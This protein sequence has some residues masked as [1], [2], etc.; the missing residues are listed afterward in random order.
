MNNNSLKIS[1]IIPVYNEEDRIFDCLNSITN[2]T[3]KPLEIIVV[4]N[5]STDQ[6]ISIADRFKDVKVIS[7]KKQGLSM[8]RN[9]GFNSARGDLL[10]RI[11]ADT[12]V[13]PEWV[14]QLKN[15]FIYDK[16]LDGISGYGRTRVGLTL[17]LIS[18]FLSWAYFTHCKAFFGVTML[19]G[20]NM[21]I[22]S[23]AWKKVRALCYLDDSMVHE[24]EDLSLALNSVGCKLQN[25]PYIRVSV[26]FGDIQYFDKFWHYNIKK[27]NTRQIH[28]QHFRSKLVTNK[29]LPF[30]TRLAYHFV[31]TWTV[32]MYMMASALNSTR[33]MLLKYS[34]NSYFYRLFQKNHIN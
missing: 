10:A 2:Q 20:S 33:R 16:N 7:E 8:A 25:V 3:V 26:D 28:R 6:T 30:G 4:D 5:N 14:Q 21:A 12:I 17:P 11:D 15:E 13:P 34:R 9:K 23:S 22:R 29:Y 32:G 31:A 1:V 19:W 27:H 18:D 24:D